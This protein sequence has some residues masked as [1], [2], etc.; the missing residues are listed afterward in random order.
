MYGETPRAKSVA[1]ARAPPE[2]VFIYSR[3]VPLNSAKVAAML[4]IS[5]PRLSEIMNGKA[6]PS[7]ALARM[8][9]LKLNISPSIVL[10]V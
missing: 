6:E 3:I 1:V 8:I 5:S 7:L 2:R 9:S 10:G 4:G